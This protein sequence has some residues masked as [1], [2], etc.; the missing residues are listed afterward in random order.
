M[1]NYLKKLSRVSAAKVW[2][3]VSNPWRIPLALNPPHIFVSSL[4][5]AHAFYPDLT[6]QQAKALRLEFLRNEAF[7]TRINEK[8]ISRRERHATY[9]QWNE[10]VYMLVRICKPRLMFE[11]GVFDGQS[12][13]VILQALHD[14]KSGELVSVDLPAR[15]TMNQST[16]CMPESA[17]PLDCQPGWIIPDYLKERHQ[18]LLGDSKKLL[19]E[20]FEKHP[21]I[22][23][24]FHDSLHTYEHMYFEYSLAWP[25]LS[26][27]GVLLSDD[28][29][30]N[31][32]FFK[33]CRENKR[34]FVCLGN[35]GA[36]RK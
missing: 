11:T 14:N 24:F 4:E 20:L 31:A 10:F 26:Q 9:L 18:L 35:F 27:G 2:D 3:L 36:T 7:F 6:V 15:S 21:Q 13:A 8:M 34:P 30:W 33:F 32:A 25:H 5:A 16:Q 29:F 22:D 28:I 12:S 1:P 19:P 23:I 17:L